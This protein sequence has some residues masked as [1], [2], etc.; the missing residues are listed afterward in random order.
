NLA[1]AV[2]NTLEL[3]RLKIRI[4]GV[5]CDNATNNDTLLESLK[6]KC[7]AEGIDFSHK[8]AWICCLPHIVHLSVMQLL[9]GIG[10]IKPDSRRRESAYQDSVTAPTDCE[11]DD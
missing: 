5:V 2:W 10:A 11:H 6:E 1:E 7:A 9:K 4:M 8:K 3:Y